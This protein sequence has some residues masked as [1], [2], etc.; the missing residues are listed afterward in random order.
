VVEGSASVVS[1]W[2]DITH[3]FTYLVIMPAK[4]I[5]TAT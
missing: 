5:R 2:T 1:W 3:E 4:P